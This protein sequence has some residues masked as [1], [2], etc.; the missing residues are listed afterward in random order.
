MKTMQSLRTDADPRVRE[1]VDQA[2]A[3]FGR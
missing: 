3:R 2:I 1:A